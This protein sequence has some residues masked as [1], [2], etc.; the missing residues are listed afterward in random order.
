MPKCGIELEFQLTVK[1][2]HLA[3]SV[4]NSSKKFNS[5]AA[6]KQGFTVRALDFQQLG[7]MELRADAQQRLTVLGLVGLRIFAAPTRRR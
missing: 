4:S 6:S 5:C 2:R 3:K 1:P 7:G